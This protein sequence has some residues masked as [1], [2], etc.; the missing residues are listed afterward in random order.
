MIVVGD[1]NIAPFAMDRCEAGPDFEKNEYVNT[2]STHALL[3][4]LLITFFY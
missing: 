2:D 4:S 3:K 1:L